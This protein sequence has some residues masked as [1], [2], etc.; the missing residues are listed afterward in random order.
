MPRTSMKPPPF[1][2]HAPRSVE[3]AVALKGRYGEDAVILAGGQSLIPLLALRLA[4]PS[5]VIDLGRVPGLD[6]VRDEDGWVALGAMVRHRTV[7]HLP[8]LSSRLPA[9]ADAVP[10][11]GHPAIRNRGT[12]GGSMAHAD[13]AAEWPTLA[14]ALDATIEAT[15][16]GGPRHIDASA[17]FVTYLTNALAPDEVVTE[18][19]LRMPGHRVGS[20]FVEQSRRHGDFALVGVAAV[21]ALDEDGIVSDARVVVMGVGA[22]PARIDDAEA[23]LRGRPSTDDHLREAGRLCREAI[24]PPGDIHG[25]P[26]YRKHIVGVV[27]RRALFL[28]RDRVERGAG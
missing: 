15:G 18:V 9:V 23:A 10:L 6:H 4:S 21:L 8:R 27:A 14:L 3:E 5:V 11:I 19:R 2:Y 22:I 28:A 25:S 17:F 24:D 13:P 16:T 7:E 20:A 26:E 12:V 1:E